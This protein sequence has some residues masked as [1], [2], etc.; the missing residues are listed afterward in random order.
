MLLPIILSGGSGTRLWPVSREAYPKPFIR[1]PSGKSLLQATLA[2]IAGLDHVS[3]VI[4]ITN[5]EHYFPTRDEYQ[6]TG[7]EL[8][9]IYILE[10]CARNT[11]QAVAIGAFYALARYGNDVTLFVLPA[12]HLIEEHNLFAAS[13]LKAQT[14]AQQGFLVT[15]GIPPVYPETGYGYIELGDPLN[16]GNG[17]RVIRFIEKPSLEVA[18]SFLAS[19]KYLWNS[20]MFCFTVSVFLDRL[21]VYAPDVYK[22]ALA[23]WHCCDPKTDKIDLDATT[24]C[25]IPSIS[26]DYALIE[27][28]DQ[29]AVVPCNFD[30]SDI[31]TWEAVS[32]LTPADS[33]GNRVQGE[34]VL[35]DSR[36]CYVQTNSRLIAAVG[37][38]N[39]IIVDTPD[40]LL[41]AQRDSVQGVK[42]VTE[43]LKLTNHPTH[44]QH[45]TVVR[46][47]GTY[48]VLE[49]GTGFKIKR[50]VV[51]PGES[52]SLQMHHHRSEHW[53]VVSGTAKV[54]NGDREML[55]RTNESTFVP[56]GNKH[57]LEN[58]GAADLVIIEVQ[59]G[60]YL[61]EDDIVR[62]EDKYDRK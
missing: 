20:G 54:I 23:C 5:K 40:A 32:Q 27:K 13:V 58:P 25:Q 11:A 46:P 30:W 50:I 36:N 31:G 34:A 38:E 52:L 16:H 29:L 51:K 28:S 43:Q 60:S 55:V 53:V 19:G 41:V 61:G 56:A 3:D 47:W 57:R 9:H 1:L 18:Q 12:D 33:N 59:S 24:F 45:R 21:K 10:P 8:N 62:F 7:F 37:L 14:L 44:R 39:V 26:I 48:T 22:G 49:E 15:F 2:R 35:M 4:T 6:S 42:Q 17:R